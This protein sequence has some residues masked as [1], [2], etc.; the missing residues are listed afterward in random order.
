MPGAVL[1]LHKI[2]DFSA[3]THLSFPPLLHHNLSLSS[4]PTPLPLTLCV[5]ERWRK[6]EVRLS[7]H[8][9]HLFPLPR[10]SL[11]SKFITLFCPQNFAWTYIPHPPHTKM[12]AIQ[13]SQPRRHPMS[14]C[15]DPS[16]SCPPCHT[17]CHR[18]KKL[19]LSFQLCPHFFCIGKT[20]W[21]FITLPK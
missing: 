1:V 17:V 18:L 15:P 9:T 3:L 16:Q 8:I 11:Y 2:E 19:A 14:G 6:E 12:V 13:Y 20:K 21:V 5:G 4:L 7:Y 10:F